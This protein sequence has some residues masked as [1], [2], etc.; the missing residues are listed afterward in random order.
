M[1]KIY[2]TKKKA[3]EFNEWYRQ[4]VF[5]IPLLM[6]YDVSG[7][8]VMLPLSYN[9]WELIQA[10]LDAMIRCNGASNVYFPLLIPESYLNKEAQHIEGF[11]P[12]IAW[13]SRTDDTD[14]NTMNVGKLA[15]RPTSECGIYPTFKKL[16][17]CQQDLPIKFNQW[18]NVLRWEFNS[19]TPFI[20]S[21]EFLWQETHCAFLDNQSADQNVKEFLS[22]YQTM[23]QDMLSVP[24][25]VGKKFESEKFSGAQA[26]YSVETYIPQGGRSIQCATSHNLGQNFSKM[27]DISV[28]DSEGNDVS[29]YQTSS[30]FTTRSIGV[31][32]MTHSDDIGLVL[33]HRVAPV[34]VVIMPIIYAKSN[35]VNERII[36]SCQKLETHLRGAGIRVQ[37]DSSDRRPAQKF[38]FHESRGVVVRIEIGAKDL[39]R[40]VVTY[41]VRSEKIKKTYSAE[42]MDC[43]VDH[44]R[45]LFGEHDKR[46]LDVARENLAKSI[47]HC[48]DIDGITASYQSNMIH[49]NIC[50]DVKCE[51]MIRDTFAIKPI[52]RPINQP[53]DGLTTSCLNLSAC[54]ICGAADSQEAYFAKTF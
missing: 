2:I 6:H 1:S 20:R 13:I 33:P 29:V 43:I 5:E 26:T 42:S 53:I 46:L 36:M 17:R 44:I 19:P 28:K 23:Y 50:D 11:T 18:C 14:V 47:I 52:C 3:T 25:I 45:Q 34:Q 9:I 22:I 41:V 16:I 12:E 30:G 51:N 40:G 54:C 49:C 15:V 8:Y 32:I 10:E 7:C 21:R 4:I 48:T 35:E 31:M 38:Y 39:E 37:L 27:F 24:V